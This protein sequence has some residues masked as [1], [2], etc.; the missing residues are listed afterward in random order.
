V[1]A[2]IGRISGRPLDIRREA[3]QKGDMRDTFADT[4]LA[5]RDLGFVPRVGLDE[6]LEAEYRWLADVPTVA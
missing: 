1:L 6:G 5:R 2:L 4:S 3:P